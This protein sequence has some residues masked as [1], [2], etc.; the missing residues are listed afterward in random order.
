MLALTGVNTLFIASSVLPHRIDHQIEKKSTNESHTKI[1]V[2]KLRT[3]YQRNV[4]FV[5]FVVFFLFCWLASCELMT[6]SNSN[7]N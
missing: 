1:Q 6:N 2:T 5:L 7:E 4:I 3:L